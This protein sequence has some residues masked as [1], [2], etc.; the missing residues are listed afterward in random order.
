MKGLGNAFPAERVKSEW[1]FSGE[2]HLQQ[3]EWGLQSPGAGT[4]SGAGSWSP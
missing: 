3:K 4:A 2:G 1:F